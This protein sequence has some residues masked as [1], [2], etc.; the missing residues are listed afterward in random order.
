[1]EMTGARR[2]EAAP[3]AGPIRSDDFREKNTAALCS[4]RAPRRFP[5]RRA[6]R[7]AR[8]EHLKSE[9]RFPMNAWVKRLF[10]RTPRTV[11]TAP[12]KPRKA[13]LGIEALEARDVPAYLSGGSLVIDGN[14]YGDT[15]SVSDYA[16]YVQVVENGSY[17][18]FYRP[19][20]TTGQLVFH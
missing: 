16:Y 2:E 19:S 3:P 5:S 8:T 1:A 12:P 4:R 20:I 14:N 9:P 11:R 10:R 6:T 17:Q 15:V 7:P 18:Y 13:R